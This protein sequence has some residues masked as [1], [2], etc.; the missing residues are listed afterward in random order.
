M[1][2]CDVWVTF[3]TEGAGYLN[4]LGYYTHPTN[5]PPDTPAAIDTITIIFPN[6]S[7]QGSGGGLR[8][9][10]KVNLGRFNAGTTITFAL[11]A[12]GWKNG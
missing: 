11:I 7:L 6:V 12:D 9:G 5:K 3:V 2:I 8:P 1:E 10:N 4:V